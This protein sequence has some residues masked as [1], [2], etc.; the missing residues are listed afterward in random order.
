M[1]INMRESK[2]KIVAATTNAG[3]LREIREILHDYEVVSAADVGFYDDIEETGETFVENA[4]I[5]A[6]TV[7]KAVGL[8]T[9]GDD[10]GLC[11][12]A[13]NGAPGIYSARYSGQGVVANR[14]LLLKNLKGIDNRNA[15]FEC[16]VVLVYP[17]GREIVVKGR[18]DGEITIRESNGGNGFGYDCLFFSNELGKTFAEATADEKNAVSHRGRALHNLLTKLN[19]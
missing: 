11:V 15:H 2:I 12:D 19:V 13:L 14:Q 17:D 16:A 3:K 7:C 4:R 6:Q 5:K 10:S 8:P 1:L 18:T 9:I